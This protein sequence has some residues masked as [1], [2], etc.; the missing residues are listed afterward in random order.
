MTPVGVI[1][2]PVAQASLQEQDFSFFVITITVK[3]R[4]VVTPA[5]MIP[6]TIVSFSL[7]LMQNKSTEND[8]LVI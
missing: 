6:Q 4:Q 7:K 5:I 8:K 3:I 2:R 1:T